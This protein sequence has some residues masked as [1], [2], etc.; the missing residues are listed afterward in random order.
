MTVTARKYGSSAGPDPRPN[1][2]CRARSQR[3][4]R[5]QLGPNPKASLALGV[6]VRNPKRVEEVAEPRVY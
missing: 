6:L 2:G 5:R 4:R 3:Q 1:P